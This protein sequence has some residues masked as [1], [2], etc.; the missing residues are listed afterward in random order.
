MKMRFAQLVGTLVLVAV[1][2]TAVAG[3]D[4]ARHQGNRFASPR[5]R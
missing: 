1:A 5:R 4:K 2:G 3:D